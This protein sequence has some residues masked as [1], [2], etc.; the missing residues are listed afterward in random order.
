MRYSKHFQGFTLIELLIV[1]AIIGILAAIAIPNFLQAQVRAK[2][3]RTQADI[4]ALA[5]GLELYRTD[6]SAYPIGYTW[7]GVGP[8]GEDPLQSLTTPVDFIAAVPRDPFFLDDP[9][10][11]LRT[12]PGPG[13]YYY[14]EI[15]LTDPNFGTGGRFRKSYWRLASAGP[16]TMHG[17]AALGGPVYEINWIDYD[18]TNGTVSVGEIMRWGP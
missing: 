14:W 11:R 4:S 12:V 8:H 1:V 9:Y 15:P 13:P 18:P 7:G 3:G 16:D 10:G 2:V 5:T 6:N 17:D